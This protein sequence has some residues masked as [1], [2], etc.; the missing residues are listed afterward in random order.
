MPSSVGASRFGLIICLAIDGG[1]VRSPLPERKWSSE[2]QRTAS[3]PAFCRCLAALTV[4]VLIGFMRRKLYWL[5][6]FV[7][8]GKCPMRSFAN[9]A[10]TLLPYHRA[11]LSE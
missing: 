8:R 2:Q 11:Q 4:L 5:V 10:I 3:N 7:G 6:I 1:I 9:S